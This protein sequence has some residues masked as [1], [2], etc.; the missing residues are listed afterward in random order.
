MTICPAHQNSARF[1]DRC[2]FRWQTLIVICCGPPAAAWAASL[3]RL[4]S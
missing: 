4:W 3:S 2:L 1:D